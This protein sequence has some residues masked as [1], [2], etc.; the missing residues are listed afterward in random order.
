M[1]LLISP[2]SVPLER[3]ASTA[4]HIYCLLNDS[5]LD[6]AESTWMGGSIQPGEGKGAI[7]NGSLE[8]SMSMPPVLKARSRW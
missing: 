7:S 5:T 4:P 6:Y 2:N 8:V 1:A 3:P